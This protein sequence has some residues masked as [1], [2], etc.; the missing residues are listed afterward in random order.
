M[1]AVL[2]YK[3]QAPIYPTYIQYSGCCWSVR[4]PLP[5]SRPAIA[6][7]YTLYSTPCLLQV[8]GSTCTSRTVVLSSSTTTPSW[9]S[10]TMSDQDTMTRW[11]PP[12]KLCKLYINGLVQDCSNSSALAMEFLQSCSKPS[13]SFHEKVFGTSEVIFSKW[14]FVVDTC[15]GN[16]MQ[17]SLKHLVTIIC[18]CHTVL[19]SCKSFC[20]HDN[21][22]YIHVQC[23]QNL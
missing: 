10:R 21:V 17:I 16:D 18:H 11:G 23:W 13:I 9:P 20:W 14:Y 3:R 6:L 15:I 2:H 19:L 8:P 22:K 12:S 1:G 5:H 7:Q 4:C